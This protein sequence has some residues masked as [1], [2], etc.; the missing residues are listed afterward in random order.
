MLGLDNKIFAYIS[1]GASDSFTYIDFI[2]QAVNSQDINGFPVL[3]LGCCIVADRA[4]IHGQ[5]ALE[6]LEP[7]LEELDIQHFYLPSY[8]PTLNLVEEAF[9]FLKALMRTTYFQKLLQFYVPTAIYES[10][11]YLTPDIVYKLFRNVSCNYMNL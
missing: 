3:Y 11:T 6:I 5:H 8:S 10:V 4:P 9:G 1:E 2:H 7:Y